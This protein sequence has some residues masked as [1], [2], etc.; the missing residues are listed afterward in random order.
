MLDREAIRDLSRRYAMG[1]D[2]RDWGMYRSI[3]TDEIEA[4]FSSWSGGEP[5]TL[6]GDAWVEGVK[7]LSGFQGT[8]HMIGPYAIDFDGPDKATSVAYMYAQHF[9]P[10]DK[11]DSFLWIGGHYTNEA[12]RVSSGWK[13]K[14]VKLT[15]TWTIGNRHIFDL[16][17]ERWAAS[18]G[19]G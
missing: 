18:G 16:A 7:R 3:F 12:V 2:L 13:F 8:Q 5:M 15:V 1:I 9:L 19:Q 17:N 10:N 11:G 6:P 4:D 14:K